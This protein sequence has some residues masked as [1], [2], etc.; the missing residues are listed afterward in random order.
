MSQPKY[1]DG[2]DDDGYPLPPDPWRKPFIHGDE[3]EAGDFQPIALVDATMPVIER[4]QHIISFGENCDSP[5]E[6]LMGAAM[7]TVFDR[8][9]FPLRLCQTIDVRIAPN[10]LL[11]VPQFA[12][13]YYRSDWAIL[14]QGLMGALLIECDGKDF[15][16]SPE[17]KAHDA[18]K[19]A[20]ALERGYLTLRFTGSQINK[21]A[22]ACARKVFDVVCSQ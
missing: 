15:H 3:S 2:L 11:L 6:T 13:G 12:W 14:S 22:D 19:D 18:R 8:A 20:A 9:G 4:V 17:Q 5:I 7:V 10:G 16:S 1:D 21:D